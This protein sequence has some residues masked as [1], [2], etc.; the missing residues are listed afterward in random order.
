MGTSPDVG[1]SRGLGRPQTLDYNEQA[2][3]A[4]I[5]EL[6]AGLGLVQSTLEI[7]LPQVGREG[8][9]YRYPCNPSKPNLKTKVLV[10]VSRPDTPKA[11][12]KEEEEFQ[13]LVDELP[14]QLS[15]EMQDDRKKPAQERNPKF[16]VFE[17]ILR[18]VA[19]ALVWLES[20]SQVDPSQH[21]ANNAKIQAF[22]HATLR[23]WIDIARHIC[24]NLQSS[25]AAL[26]HTPQ[27]E[28]DARTNAQILLKFITWAKALLKAKPSQ[29]KRILKKFKKDLLLMRQQIETKKIRGVFY[30]TE[31]LIKNLIDHIGTFE[32]ENSAA[33]LTA[34]MRTQES[35][36]F[37]QVLD[38]ALKLLSKH[39]DL[40]P[41]QMLFV[42]RLM[43]FAAQLFPILSFAASGKHAL[44]AKSDKRLKH[45]YVQSLAMRLAAGLI[46]E[47]D[48]IELAAKKLL[49]AIGL[50]ENANSSLTMITEA[51]AM[52]ILPAANADKAQPL[53]NGVKKKLSKRLKILKEEATEKELVASIRQADIA[54]NRSEN[55]SGYFEAIR[56]MLRPQKMEFID[57]QGECREIAGQAF[58]LLSALYIMRTQRDFVSA[59][60]QAA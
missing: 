37:R 60:T 29:Q 8:E 25:P 45:E 12:P 26:L 28:R 18:F 7:P 36:P 9:R 50:T 27:G 54:L 20:V 53:M 57:L 3:T 5:A 16:I 55:I 15:L 23:G 38:P 58:S 33:T 59:V 14:L 17:L 51:L 41:I 19:K 43:K 6:K 40:Q 32:N 24:L 42:P 48:V 11:D 4:Q 39:P 31:S 47:S 49:G 10:G 30:V 44:D 13:R 22:S 46:S 35:T 52:N 21:S 34:I 2:Q 56:R 1:G